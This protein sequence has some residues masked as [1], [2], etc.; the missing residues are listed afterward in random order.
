MVYNKSYTKKKHVLSNKQLTRQLRS[1][2]GTNGQRFKNPNPSLLY[3]NVTLAAGTADLNYFVDSSTVSNVAQKTLH[4]IN[5]YVKLL[6]TSA[7]GATIRLIYGFDEE[8]RADGSASEILD[9][10]TDSSSCYASEC[11]AIAETRHKNRQKKYRHAVV[12]DM[13]IPLI[14]NEPKMLRLRLPLYNRIQR[15]DGTEWSFRPWMLALSDEASST[16]SV[17]FETIATD[18]D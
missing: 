18:L 4:Y 10:A 13:M 8:G 3:S 5:A 15:Y 12:R 11:A 17:G 6:C 16:I 7:S 14:A 1:I 9:T 2:K